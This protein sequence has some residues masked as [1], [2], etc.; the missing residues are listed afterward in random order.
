MSIMLREYP[1]T[2]GLTP[3]ML[4]DVDRWL[5]ERITAGSESAAPT[6]CPSD[7]G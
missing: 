3:Q 1:G 7:H 5:M 6:A 2:D 4:S